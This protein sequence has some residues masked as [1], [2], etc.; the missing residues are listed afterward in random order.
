MNL[1]S[2]KRFN[3]EAK[4]AAGFYN[5][6][7]EPRLNI[8][9]V[10]E[11]AGGVSAT[12][13]EVN[14]SMAGGV[15]SSCYIGKS[16]SATGEDFDVAYTAATQL[17]L[18]N[19]PAGVTA[20]TTT[21]IEAIRQINAAGSVVATYHRDDVAMTMSGAVYTRSYACYWWVY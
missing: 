18:S 6:T 19:F 16:D 11:I 15:D 1:T 4:E 7:G 9:G 20:F 8:E 17:T 5:E 12:V 14:M 10:V 21:D 3:R 2:T 13:E